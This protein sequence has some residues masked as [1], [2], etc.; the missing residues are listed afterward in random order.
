M[1]NIGVVHRTDD[2]PDYEQRPS[3]RRK[4]DVVLLP[5]GP[6]A[7]PMDILL[8]ILER[9]AIG[10]CRPLVW[11]LRE[12]KLW[13]NQVY[14][15]A[16][17][18]KAV[19][20]HLKPVLKIIK[21]IYALMRKYMHMHEDLDELSRSHFWPIS[22]RKSQ[23]VLFRNPWTHQTLMV[24]PSPILFEIF[25]RG[26]YGRLDHQGLPMVVLEDRFNPKDV[27]ELLRLM[28]ESLHYRVGEVDTWYELTPLAAAALNFQVGMEW[29][30]VL[31]KHGAD[32]R[33]T[34]RS[35]HTTLTIYEELKKVADQ[36]T[37]D[38]LDRSFR[39]ARAQLVKST[40]EG[41]RLK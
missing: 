19:L 15:L 32:P 3:K 24:C 14:L 36:E 10:A 35:Y 13:Y 6:G 26:I 21:R 11:T 23:E 8:D 22:Y 37:R 40:L 12:V 20:R 9:A 4:L 25:S 1:P 31:L 38:P 17:V 28:P 27:F 34:L 33:Q 5:S 18:S 41:F 2:L 7:I 30:E 16:T 39:L 29:I